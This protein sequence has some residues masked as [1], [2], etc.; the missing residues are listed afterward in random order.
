ML[1]RAALA[2]LIAAAVLA[3]QLPDAAHGMAVPAPAPAR[4]TLKRS[5]RAHQWTAS[6][7]SGE[8]WTNSSGPVGVNADIQEIT[9]QANLKDGARRSSGPSCRPR[10]MRCMLTVPVVLLGNVEC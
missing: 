5:F 10:R 7:A 3:L 1:S 9:Q 8:G 4:P 6:I 2:V